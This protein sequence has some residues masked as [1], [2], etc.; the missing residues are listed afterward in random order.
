MKYPEKFHYGVQKLFQEQLNKRA[1]INA[2]SFFL[3]SR[4]KNFES[5][6]DQND[7]LI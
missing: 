5:P 4:N 3:Y 1:K 6:Q 7:S 2:K